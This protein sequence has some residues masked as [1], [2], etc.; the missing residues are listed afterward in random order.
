M[1]KRPLFSL[2]VLL[3]FTS[4]LRAQSNVGEL[5]LKVTD[6]SG[7]GVKSAIELVC[8]ANQFRQIYE[9][10]SSGAATARRLAFGI[11]QVDVQQQGFS[12]FHN[13]VEIRSA[14]PEEF[15]ISLS[16]A[17]VNTSVT[18]K[19][20]ETLV[21]PH[22]TGSANRIGAET[23]ENRGSLDALQREADRQQCDGQDWRANAGGEISMR[24]QPSLQDRQDQKDQENQVHARR[25]R[26]CGHA[27][28]PGQAPR[29]EAGA[30][31]PRG[32]EDDGQA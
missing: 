17:S 23:I 7:S 19:D 2:A 6:P 27:R 16:L 12:A 10:D 20:T 32:S 31:H 14:V 5:R 28:E 8:E 13:V 4:E 29:Q 21:D 18:V 3:L 9:T 11:Y 22:R 1:R 30:G 25:D 24:S 15:R 26:D